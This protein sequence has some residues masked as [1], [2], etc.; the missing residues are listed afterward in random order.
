MT[1]PRRQSIRQ[2]MTR[3]R[4]LEAIRPGTLVMATSSPSPRYFLRVSSGW[5]AA[6]YRGCTALQ[7]IL[8]AELEGWPDAL[9]S[10]DLRLPAVIVSYPDELDPALPELADIA[11]LAALHDHAAELGQA[12][13]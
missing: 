5:H 8:S 13:A 11:A 3:I 12:V 10:S 9:H 4:E 7:R 2:P 6:D 1:G